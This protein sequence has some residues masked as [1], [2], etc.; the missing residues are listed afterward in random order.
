MGSVP[1]WVEYLVNE[2]RYRITPM[3]LPFTVDR[4]K[5]EE[6]YRHLGTSMLG[7]RELSIPAYR[8]LADLANG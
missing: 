1:V 3:G 6:L 5:Y 2:N 7:M 4:E 8:Q